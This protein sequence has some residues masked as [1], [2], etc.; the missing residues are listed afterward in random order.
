MQNLQPLPRA[1]VMHM[2]QSRRRDEINAPLRKPMQR[3]MRP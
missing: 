3:R 2:M 1:K